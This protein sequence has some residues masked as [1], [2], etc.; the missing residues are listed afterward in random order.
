[1]FVIVFAMRV[2][3]VVWAT[4]LGVAPLAAS[5]EA[6]A[7]DCVSVTNNWDSRGREVVSVS[8]T[9]DA[10][11]RSTCGLLVERFR[12]RDDPRANVNVSAT[13][14]E[15][16]NPRTAAEKRFN[17]WI[18]SVV[19]TMDFDRPLVLL[20]NEKAED[21]LVLE[22]IYRSGR[23]ISAAYSRWLCCGAHGTTVSGSINIDV[24]SGAV[25]SPQ[26]LFS[27]PAVANH[28]WQQF[29][30]L[31]GPMDGQGDLFKQDYPMDRSFSV[32]DFEGGNPSVSG[33]LKP[34]VDKTV[35]LFHATLKRSSNWTITD[36][37]TAVGFGELL[38][39]VGAAFDCTIDNAALKPMAQP[40]VTVPP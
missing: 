12:A 25:V 28:C 36:R 9:G 20:E 14:L 15:F 26:E 31:P 18:G 22:S 3:H 1:L 16:D 13:Y 6:R 40:G 37:G 34:S 39:Y 17:E 23:L 32:G 21:I 30:A 33:P 24:A 7:V 11:T 35:R 38:G 29:A 27:L 19:A 4:V 2:R 5:Q 10:G 8:P